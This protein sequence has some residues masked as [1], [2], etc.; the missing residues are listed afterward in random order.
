MRFTSQPFVI[1]NTTRLSIGSDVRHG[2]NEVNS[3]SLESVFVVHRHSIRAPTYFPAGDPYLNRDNYPRG[4]GYLTKKGVIACGSIANVWS[5]WYPEHIH[6][7]D[8]TAVFVRSS[9]SPR[10]HQTAQAILSALFSTQETIYPVPVYGPPPGF[11]NYISVV[12]YGKNINNVLRSHYQDSV[13]QPNTLGAVTF[14]DVIEAV[15]DVMT[16]PAPLE[17]EVFTFL[18]GIVSNMY[19]DH[20]IPDFWTRN[21][22]IL[23]EVYE[24]LYALVIEQ[25]RPYYGGHLLRGIAQRMKQVFNKE[26]SSGTRWCDYSFH[27][28]SLTAIYHALEG[29][30][31]LPKPHFLAAIFFELRTANDGSHWVEVYHSHGIAPDGSYSPREP[32]RMRWN[33]GS[34][35]VIFEKIFEKMYN[36]VYIDKL[37]GANGKK[38]NHE[39]NGIF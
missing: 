4:A 26:L 28:F 10:C 22:R 39:E 9:E 34:H 7:L 1:S 30:I 11:D 36:N 3:D 16:V 15:K 29:E 23:T 37:L 35:R 2:Q 33:G 19:E 20:P 27:D 17:Y 31:N 12:G 14:G 6:G 25:Y 8:H 21:E 32:M 18:D 24:K 38:R 5:S 13:S